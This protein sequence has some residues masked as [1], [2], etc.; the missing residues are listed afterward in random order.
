ALT[1]PNGVGKSTLLRIVNGDVA[2]TSGEITR[3]DGRVA[4]LSQ[5]LDLL[6]PARTV[7]ENFA[8]SAPGLPAPERMNILARFLFRGAGAHL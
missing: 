7:A 2:P 5:R 3:A 8:L 6:D 4:Y 1:G